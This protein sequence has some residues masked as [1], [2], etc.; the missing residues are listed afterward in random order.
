MPQGYAS[1]LKKKLSG[2]GDEARESRRAL[3]KG[4]GKWALQVV[5]ELHIIHY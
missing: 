5:T 3:A 4:D 2:V 1:N